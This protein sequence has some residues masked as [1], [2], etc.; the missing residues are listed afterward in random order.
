MTKC[1]QMYS[2]ISTGSHITD[3]CIDFCP[4][5]KV[6]WTQLCFST[7]F[8]TACMMTL[9]FLREI[10]NINTPILKYEFHYALGKKKN[11]T[12]VFFNERHAN[13]SL[14]LCFGNCRGVQHLFH[15]CSA[16]LLC[17]VLIWL[18]HII[19]QRAAIG[20]V[21]P[22]YTWCTQGHIH[23]QSCTCNT[24]TCI[25]MIPSVLSSIS[26]RVALSSD[27]TEHHHRA[28]FSPNSADNAGEPP[29]SYLS[30]LSAP[31]K[32]FFSRAV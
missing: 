15:L 8:F 23:C 24:L 14:C 4:D 16:S 1:Y 19:H 13:T 12:R 25:P 22:T 29:R 17:P 30:S 6:H 28:H 27:S 31:H 26:P 21:S 18:W 20:F 5:C 11:R 3:G 32:E 10:W 7:L 9:F 2:F